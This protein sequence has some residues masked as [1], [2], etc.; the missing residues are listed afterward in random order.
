V[1]QLRREVKT[2]EVFQVSEDYVKIFKGYSS[3]L[4]FVEKTVD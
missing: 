3:G 1:V 4:I 2:K